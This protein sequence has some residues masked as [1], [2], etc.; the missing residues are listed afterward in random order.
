MVIRNLIALANRMLTKPEER[1]TAEREREGVAELEGERPEYS[2][3]ERREIAPI[4]AESISGNEPAGKEIGQH[5]DA[6]FEKRP[7]EHV[8]R[9]AFYCLKY[10]F[11]LPVERARKYADI[12]AANKH[13]LY[14]GFQSPEIYRRIIDDARKMKQGVRE[15]NWVN[16]VLD[17]PAKYRD[18]FER[19][20]RRPPG[21]NEFLSEEEWQR[22]PRRGSGSQV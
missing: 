11:D 17:N 9:L 6:F 20:R 7:A 5:I 21:V 19:F 3:E 13:L 1:V 2:P 14:G 15:R 4:W 8:R 22:P 10:G 12:V 18:I 16:I